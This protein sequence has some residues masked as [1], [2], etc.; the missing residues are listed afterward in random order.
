MN[1]LF[2]WINLMCSFL[3][4]RWWIMYF[5]FITD[6]SWHGLDLLSRV[7]LGHHNPLWAIWPRWSLFIPQV[8]KLWSLDLFVY[9]THQFEKLYWTGI[10][11]E[12]SQFLTFLEK[13]W[14]DLRKVGP[15]LLLADWTVGEDV[16]SSD[17]GFT[18]PPWVGKVT[19]CPWRHVLTG[20][21]YCRDGAKV[22]NVS[23]RKNWFVC[24]YIIMRNCKL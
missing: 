19:I 24:M 17:R 2:N 15:P 11:K 20:V 7:P 3:C 14:D 22:P 9:P 21:Q 16:L 1:L 4:I 23:K 6:W 8:A 5:I 12:K 18:W 13:K 10:Y